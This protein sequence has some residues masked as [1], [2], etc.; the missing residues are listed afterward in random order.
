MK[1]T[2]LQIKVVETGVHAHAL[3]AET[4]ASFYQ[5]DERVMYTAFEM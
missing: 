3:S 1:S 4:A 2:F 5:K